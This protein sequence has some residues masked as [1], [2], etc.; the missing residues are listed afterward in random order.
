MNSSRSVTNIR[1]E[2]RITNQQSDVAASRAILIVGSVRFATKN[3]PL[4]FLLRQNYSILGLRVT[5]R[6]CLYS[7]STHAQRANAAR[8]R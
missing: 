2:E 4:F 6:R 5:V 1:D 3:Q 7:D 8:R